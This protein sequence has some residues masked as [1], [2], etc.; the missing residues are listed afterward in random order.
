ME[1][2]QTV[3]VVEKEVV[4]WQDRIV[5]EE[6]PV[7]TVERTVTVPGPAGPTVTVEKIVEKEKV[8]T[9]RDST[10]SKDVDREEKKEEVKITDSRPWLAVEGSGNLAPGTGKWAWTGGAQIRVLGPVWLGP[11]VVKADGWYWGLGARVEF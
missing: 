11:N 2:R 10:G 7:R 3:Q 1:T 9:V 8:V 5:V 4:K 6:G